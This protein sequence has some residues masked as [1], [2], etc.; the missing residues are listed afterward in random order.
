MQV[1][2][3]VLVTDPPIIVKTKQMIARAPPSKQVLS[4]AQGIVHWQPPPAATQ[5]AGQL[6]NV[7]EPSIHGYGPADGLPRLKEALEHKLST[8]NN[9]Q[10][11]KVMVTA[12]ANQA[13]VNLVLT[14]C[15]TSDKVVLFAPYY[16]NHL[17]ALQM[18]GGADQVALGPCHPDTLHPDLEW[19]QQQLQGPHPPRLV[20][21]VN[22]C[23]PTGV[24]LPVEELQRA[25][26]MCAAAGCWL[27]LDNTYEDFVYNGRQHH[28]ISA[29]NVIHVFSFSKAYGMMGWRIGYIAYPSEQLSQGSQQLAGYQLAS[30]LMKVG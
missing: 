23:N 21:I 20:V 22:P 28:A 18:T 10:G 1:S 8:K 16:F 30:E 5:L 6:L 4:L 29:P 12:G 7:G 24:L 11:Y 14:L 2:K 9:L 19:L 27:V 3:R 15:D 17:M 13:F 26:D 25:T